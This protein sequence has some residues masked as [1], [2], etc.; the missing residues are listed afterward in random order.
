MGIC[1]YIDDGQRKFSNLKVD[2]KIQGMANNNVQEH[3]AALNMISIMI[4][5]NDNRT[6]TIQLQID[7]LWNMIDLIGRKTVQFENN[8]Y[9]I[10]EKI[11]HD[12]NNYFILTNHYIGKA[13]NLHE[14]NDE[15][16]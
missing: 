8:Y 5:L 7:W 6:F 4:N 3:T 16:F 9:Q 13:L 14:R 11:G 1:Y 10:L 12:I 15:I 2:E